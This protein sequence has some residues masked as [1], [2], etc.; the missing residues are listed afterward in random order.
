M[1]AP[2]DHADTT[3]RPLPDGWRWVRLGEVCAERIETRDPRQRPQLHFRYVD[4]SSVD[5]ANKRIVSPK[6]LLGADAPSRARQV[7]RTGDVLVATTRPNLNAV[8]LVPPELDQ[9][10]CSTGFCVLRAKADLA[11]DFLFAWVQT[12][13]FVEGLVELVKGALYPAVT[14]K[15]VLA[16]AIPLPPL[17]EQQRIAALLR[18]QMAAVERARKAIEEQLEAINK[19]PAAILRQAFNGE[20]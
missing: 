7:I 6:Y 12:P 9:E 2:H 11:P 1:S 10:I 14:D 20:L 13:E 16:Q 3:K 8:A 19:L 15:Q 4:I 17:A 5:N 18:E